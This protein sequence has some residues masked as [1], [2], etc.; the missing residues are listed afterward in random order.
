MRISKSGLDGYDG[1]NWMDALTGLKKPVKDQEQHAISKIDTEEDISNAVNNAANAA[2]GTPK[3][4]M[5][6]E[7]RI[8]SSSR[9]ILDKQAADLK[10]LDANVIKQKLANSNVDPV[11]L[12]VVKKE[13]WDSCTDPV[14]L[15]KFA[16]EAAEMQIRANKNAWQANGIKPSNAPTGFD[17]MSRGSKVMPSTAAGAADDNA[18]VI[19]R[20]MPSNSNSIFDYLRLDKLAAEINKHDASVTTS[21]QTQADKAG[22]SKDWR[23]EK[24]DIPEDLP[25]MNGAT[26]QK[27]GGHDHIS[28]RYR[29]PSNQISI[30][31]DISANSPEELKQK[32][33]ALFTDKVRDNQKLIRE[34]NAKRTEKISRKIEEKSKIEI[35]K[36]ETTADKQKRFMD[37]WAPPSK[38]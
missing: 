11:A 15:D 17:A 22:K 28:D 37:I 32:I 27:S 24:H 34:E 5:K 21:K 18:P 26:V 14:R 1:L 7:E 38:E 8:Q 36:P 13:E 6:Q 19:S 16:R 25:I 29:A 9:S 4:E 2:F 10:T 33:E 23:T 12:G 30:M 3:K 35:T 20:Q 31:D